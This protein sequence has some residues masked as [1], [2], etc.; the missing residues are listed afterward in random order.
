MRAKKEC[1]IKAFS[2]SKPATW[3]ATESRNWMLLG[4]LLLPLL[5]F[6][7]T[8]NRGS[9]L[10]RLGL[11]I[12]GLLGGWVVARSSR[13]KSF[14]ER[15]GPFWKNNS[16][17]AAVVILFMVMVLGLSPRAFRTNDDVGIMLDIRG[18]FAVSFM[19]LILGRGL[20][21]LYGMARSI[22]FYGIFL[23]FMHACSLYLFIKAFS[24]LRGFTPWFPFFLVA[25]LSLYARFLME[26]S[27][28]NSAF[29]IGI[30]ALMYCGSRLIEGEQRT[31]CFMLSGLLFA[32]CFMV[33]K[34]VLPGVL[35]FSAVMLAGILFR[36]KRSW[37]GLVIFFIPVMLIFSAE[38]L[39]A[40]YGV[41]DTYKAFKRFNSFRSALHGYPILFQNRNNRR[42]LMANGWTKNDMTLFRFYFFPNERKFNETTM[43]NFFIERQPRRVIKPKD[44]LSGT[45]R[46]LDE[47]PVQFFLLASILILT[48]FLNG[49][50]ESTL[51]FFNA[52]Y[53]SAGMLSMTLVARFPNRI[54]N[55]LFLLLLESTVFFV[56]WGAANVVPRKPWN[57]PLYGF[58]I[59]CCMAVLL[60]NGI[61]YARRAELLTLTMRKAGAIMQ[62]MDAVYPGALF[63][64]PYWPWAQDIDP[65]RNSSFTFERIPTGWETFSERF[66]E[67]IGRRAGVKYGYDLFPRFLKLQNAY[68]VGNKNFIRGSLNQYLRETYRLRC[69]FV[70]V[71]QF[72]KS[73][74]MFRVFGNAG[75]WRERRNSP[76]Q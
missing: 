9:V 55:P 11:G 60:L 63:L 50:K 69:K 29:M 57:R 73:T 54:G 5:Y 56:F 19:S 24:R 20:S 43:K 62:R 67:I 75:D 41:S 46:L 76:N 49:F 64:T 61:A 74:G 32:F 44:V 14:A 7:M 38:R 28:N 45:R 59:A 23:Y 10:A 48:F 2:L 16:C 15:I 3:L 51:I 35:L 21:L 25:Y 40:R 27:Y 65:L 26:V 8:K 66:Y 70:K 53:I 42:L 34:Q 18:G 30:N 22:P 31:F 47:Y 36:E 17:I 52:V 4:I 39:V 12:S 13:W 58:F 72:G 37:K 68:I 6:V 33:R 71:E 1:P